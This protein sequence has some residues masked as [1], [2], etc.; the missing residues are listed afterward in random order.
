VLIAWLPRIET[1][2]S[3]LGLAL[4][5]AILAAVLG[6]PAAPKRPR[7]ADWLLTGFLSL[8]VTLSGIA[9]WQP[10]LVPASW[11]AVAFSMHGWASYAWL[12]WILIHTALRLASFQKKH[13]LNTRFTYQRRDVLLS[14]V[15]MA[16]AGVQFLN[17]AGRQREAAVAA[18][19]ASAG[20]SGTP[21]VPLFP[22]YYTFTGAYPDIKPADYRLAVEGL[23]DHPLILTLDDLQKI[24]PEIATRNFDC[25]TGWSV[26]D[27]TWTGVRLATLLQMVGAR[28]EVTHMIFHSA[29]GSYVDQLTIK[30]AMLPGVM[31][32]YHINGQPL[33]R[34]G[35]YQANRL[36]VMR[37]GE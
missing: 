21:K 37:S 11:D 10:Q 24:K 35:G 27:V 5:A 14:T 31:L 9:L 28:P 7:W 2:H 26:P 34:E 18:E 36:N 1:V 25:V 8:I 32:A 17:L 15:G 23:A 4:A 12:A 29:D 30:D 6:L 22:A 33:L 20:S 3:L 19:A 13:P 16:V